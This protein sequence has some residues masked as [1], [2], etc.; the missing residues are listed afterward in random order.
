MK[1]KLEQENTE[2]TEGVFQT[3]SVSSW[4]HQQWLEVLID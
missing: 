3:L 2:E 1:A 4:F